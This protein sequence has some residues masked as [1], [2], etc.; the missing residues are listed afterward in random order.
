[1][2][3]VIAQEMMIFDMSPPLSAP[4][5]HGLARTARGGKDIE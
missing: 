3:P 1:M 2:D 5:W 4:D